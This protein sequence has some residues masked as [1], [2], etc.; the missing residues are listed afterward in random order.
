VSKKQDDLVSFLAGLPGVTFVNVSNDGVS[1]M[2]GPKYEKCRQLHERGVT[3][4]GQG[5]HADAIRCFK[6]AI[7]QGFHDSKAYLNVG[8]CYAELSQWHEALK[9]LRLAR[10]KF[11]S[12]EQIRRNLAIAEER[13]TGRGAVRSCP[14]CGLQSSDDGPCRVCGWVGGAA[15]GLHRAEERVARAVR[16]CP[17][18]GLQSSDDGPCRACGWVGGTEAGLHRA[19]ERAAHGRRPQA[20]L[21]SAGNAQ[22]R[23]QERSRPRITPAKCGG[24]GKKVPVLFA[25]LRGWK[26]RTP[27]PFQDVQWSCPECLRSSREA[28]LNDLFRRNPNARR[29]LEGF[30]SRLVSIYPRQGDFPEGSASW[31]TCREIGQA[32]HGK[33]GMDGMQFVVA[34]VHFHLGVSGAVDWAWH[35]IGE[36]MR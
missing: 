8:V 19:E 22:Q 25:A 21:V 1:T 13:A 34:G 24:C 29:E 14:Q 23:T 16:S 4:H 32:I 28:R 31:S 12:D 27:G 17:Q 30:V 18:C 33:Y 20:A 36:W 10:S 15:A 26:K 9:W 7:D 2:E 6:D 35:G 11:P 5:K 3:L